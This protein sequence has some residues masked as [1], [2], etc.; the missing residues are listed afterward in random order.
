MRLS[1]PE[2]LVVA[3]IAA[4]G[5]TLLV[6]FVL[7][8]RASG[9]QLICEDRL[10]RLAQAVHLHDDNHDA[11]PGYRN[12][13]WSAGDVSW[14]VPLLPYLSSTDDSQHLQMAYDAL[15]QAKEGPTRLPE[16]LCPAI[17]NYP[18]PAPLAYIANC[19]MPDVTTEDQPPDWQA[20]GIFFN[21][22]VPAEQRVS[23][24]LAWI[25]E[26]DGTK[27][28]MMFSEN[29]DAISWKDPT[30][31]SLGFVW[32]ANMTD[33]LPTSLP[34]VWPINHKRGQGD[35]SIVSARPA[36]EHLGGAN[37]V[38]ASGTTQ[39][40]SEAIDYLVFQRMMTP[41]G[42]HVK[43]AGQDAPLPKPWRYVTK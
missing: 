39:F 1:K 9:R 31:A 35:G 40:L 3:L 13:E 4:I 6:P 42:A 26:H 18:R 25:S 43:P 22:D 24:S 30:E 27:V 20:N 5:L 41:D 10:R 37:I 7:H 23:T 34:T 8:Q 29:V 12:A 11:L 17:G 36:S 15:Q 38:M 33:D 28:T 32:A 21:H 19:G 14:V 2:L 16:L